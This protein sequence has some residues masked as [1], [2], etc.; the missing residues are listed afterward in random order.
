MNKEI[1]NLLLSKN[2]ED[3]ELG[4]ILA[5]KTNQPIEEINRL[6]G[7]AGLKCRV[8]IVKKYT[9]YKD[10]ITDFTRVSYENGNWGYIHFT[11]YLEDES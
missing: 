4:F 6:Y 3:V 5:R 10:H 8:S 9:N 11:K 2:E 1:E 7:K